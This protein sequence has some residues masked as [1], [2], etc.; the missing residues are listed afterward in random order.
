MHGRANLTAMRLMDACEHLLCEAEALEDL[1]ARRIAIEANATPSAIAY[2]FGSQEELVAAVAERVY[3]RLNAERLRLLQKAIDRRAPD[4]PN[5]EEV[6][7]ALVGPSIR[8]SLD[9]TSSYPV[10]SHFTSM[11]KTHREQA[12]HYRRIIDNVEHHRAF[13]PHLKRIS[14]WLDEVDIGWRLNCALGIR[15]QVTRS[16][17]RT[18]VLT[19]YRMNLDDPEIVI[20]RMV[21]VIAPMFRRIA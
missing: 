18:E 2:H 8:W 19:N 20:T 14:P 1:T 6:I 15:S 12:P 21:E 4:P 7:A 13:I 11:A 5:L 16:R 3:R 17:S 10:L 9:P